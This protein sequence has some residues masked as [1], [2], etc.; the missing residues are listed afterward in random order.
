MISLLLT[1]LLIGWSLTL[2][3][4][5]LSVHGVLEDGSYDQMKHKIGANSVLHPVEFGTTLKTQHMQ[6]VLDY[7]Q[8]SFGDHSG[9]IGLGPKIDLNKYI[10]LGL[11][12][13]LYVRES[14]LT[15]NMPL[16]V[17]LGG[18]DLIG[19]PGVTLGMRLPVTDR[20]S[21]EVNTLSNY[22]ITHSTLGLRL[23]F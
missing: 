23:E 5:G 13:G 14:M 16:G 7:F 9:F 20:I 17:K 15:G 11:V 12:G 6:Y 8:N 19:L 21:L 4:P 18:I 3:G 10:S 2:N 22:Y 1:Q